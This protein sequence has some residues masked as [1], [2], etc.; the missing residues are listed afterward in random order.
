MTEYAFRAFELRGWS[1]EHTAN[2]YLD[3]FGQV[4]VQAIPALL[5]AARVGGGTRLLDVATGPGY[6]AAAAAELGA[7]V[8]GIDFS[9]TMVEIAK[10]LYPPIDFRQG[11]AQALD[12]ETGSFDAVIVAYGILHFSDPD[13][14]IREAFRVL[15]PGGSFAFSVWAD[16]NSGSGM[17]Y[18]LNAI[19][20]HGRMDVPLPPGPPQFRFSAPKESERVLEASGFSDT[21]T[22]RVEQTWSAPN[23]DAWLD[24]VRG[25]S[26]RLQALLAAQ[27]PEALHNIRDVVVK[28]LEPHT[29]ADGAVVVPMP[30]LVGWGRKPL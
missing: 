9:P 29:A 26:V 3:T 13:L 16:P 2:E 25:G 27:T 6:V 21:G 5:E 19:Q 18:V 14:A 23:A 12:F 22:R 15:K 28:A 24:G 7:L 11:D 17:G 4:T 20:R 10:H 1:D 30:A 8:T